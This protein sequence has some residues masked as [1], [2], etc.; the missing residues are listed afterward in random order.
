MLAKFGAAGA[1]TNAAVGNRLC[2]YTLFTPLMS[3]NTSPTAHGHSFN[4]FPP[5]VLCKADLSYRSHPLPLHR[6]FQCSLKAVN[7]LALRPVALYGSKDILTSSRP[8][9]AADLRTCIVTPL[10]DQ[11]C[12]IL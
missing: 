6:P 12:D 9:V 2:Y 10:A 4:P 8:H 1:D 11:S 5:L 7:A 3:R